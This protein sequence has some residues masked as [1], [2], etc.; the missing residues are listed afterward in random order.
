MFRSGLS[1]VMAIL[2]LVVCLCS[3][4]AGIARQVD[5]DAAQALEKL[6]NARK[7]LS[8]GIFR[9]VGRI[10][11]TKSGL[12]MSRTAFCA[13]DREKN[14]LRFDTEGDR[15][16]LVQS[17]TTA[18]ADSVKK[19]MTSLKE[20][21]DTVPLR[22]CVSR[23]A[24]T[25]E[26]FVE[27]HITGRQNEPNNSMTHVQIRELNEH[28]TRF[29]LD[30]F[31]PS[32]AG[33]IEP[34][35]FRKW[36]TLSEILERYSSYSDT[37]TAHDTDDG[38]V[39]LVYSGAQV[40]ITVTIDPAQGFTVQRMVRVTKDPDGTVR[41]FPRA[42]S[43]AKWEQIH[44]TWV[45]TYLRAFVTYSADDAR[46]REYDIN[47]EKVNP[48]SIDPALFTY[49]SFQGIWP[50]T[51][52]FKKVGTEVT[53]IDT[54]GAEFHQIRAKNA[55]RTGGSTAPPAAPEPPGQARIWLIVFNLVAILC[56]ISG[57][58]WRRLKQKPPR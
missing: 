13:F 51:H 41:D 5:A 55:V 16:I 8:S 14:L 27:W 21:P 31:D 52:V 22:Y 39:E 7:D 19:T 17:G 32:A 36:G 11:G 42:S 45:P 43:E 15:W 3:P 57:L 24:H 44:E 47:W 6:Q 40:T 58:F 48:E 56:M 50:G 28:P 25:A 29:L 54:I 46:T 12:T 23:Y 1:R 35:E 2:P 49:K 37:I 9:A 18:T 4:G 20:E 38:L 10:S 33:L 34:S 53:H 26:H 30:R